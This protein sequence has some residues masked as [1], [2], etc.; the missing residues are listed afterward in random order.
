MKCIFCKSNCVKN[1][2]DRKLNQRFKCQECKKTFTKETQQNI[3]ISKKRRV[4]LHLILA[5]CKFEEIAENLKIPVKT[6]K[7]WQNTHLKGISEILPSSPLLWIGS[8]IP[9]Y[10]AIEKSKISKLNYRRRSSPF[11]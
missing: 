10:N 3:L 4:A 7:K 5:G 6:I 1:G 9:I 8:L 11:N 2:H